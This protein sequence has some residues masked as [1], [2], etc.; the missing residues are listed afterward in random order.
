MRNSVVASPSRERTLTL[1]ESYLEICDGDQSAAILLSILEFWTGHEH[2]EQGIRR[3]ENVQEAKDGNDD[4]QEINGAMWVRRTREEIVSDSFG[5]LNKRNV[6]EA[7]NTLEDWGLIETGFPF[8]SDG[9]ND[10]RYRLRVDRLNDL[11]RQD[12]LSAQEADHQREEEIQA[13]E[14]RR[15]K[16]ED[17]DDDTYFE[18]GDWQMKYAKRWWKRQD[19]LEGE[20][21]R[22]NWRQKKDQILQKWASAFDWV[23]GR[24]M[25]KESLGDLIRFMYEEE[26]W[27]VSSGNLISPTKLKK[28]NDQGQ[29]RYEEWRVKMNISDSGTGPGNDYSLPEE[30]D[31]VPEW[32]VE[33]IIEANGET[34]M[35]DFL[36][37]GWTEDGNSKLYAYQP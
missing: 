19:E 30:G 35:E 34:S 3:R 27:W 11:M 9:D 22:Y 33:K 18:D 24:D 6:T 7:A 20:R 29:Y 28:K 5:L 23:V 4:L 2:R 16:K 10:K 12:M 25:T 1:R 8:R 13:K 26:G 37:C 36:S 15:R 17:P 14:E 21:I 31:E 32:K